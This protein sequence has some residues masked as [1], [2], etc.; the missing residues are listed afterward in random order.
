MMAA[1]SKIGVQSESKRADPEGFENT[2]TACGLHA[3]P[4]LGSVATESRMVTVADALRRIGIVS[5]II[6]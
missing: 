6:L 4:I 3:L 2:K 5:M 1:E